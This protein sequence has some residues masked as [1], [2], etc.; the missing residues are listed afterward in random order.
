MENPLVVLIVAITGVL[1]SLLFTFLPGLKTWYENQHG[2]KALIM[3][4]LMLLV[5]IVYFLLGC[6]PLIAARLSIIVACTANGAID[7]GL[8]FVVAILSNQSTYVLTKR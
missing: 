6:W 2:Y 7:M 8:A 3:V 1:I 5:S 4:G